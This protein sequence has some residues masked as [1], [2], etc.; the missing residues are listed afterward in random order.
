MLPILFTDAPIIGAND[1]TSTDVVTCPGHT[2]RCGRLMANPTIPVYYVP[3]LPWV[4]R[5]MMCLPCLNRHPDAAKRAVR[6]VPRAI[7]DV[8]CAHGDDFHLDDF[9]LVWQP[10]GDDNAS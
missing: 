10:A 3:G 1:I 4:P 8:E 9:H 7:L 2:C 5:E 6:L